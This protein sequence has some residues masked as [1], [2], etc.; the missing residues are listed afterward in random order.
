MIGRPEFLAVDGMIHL[1]DLKAG[2]PFL[3]IF[4][5]RILTDLLH[6]FFIS[7]PAILQGQSIFIDCSRLIPGKALDLNHVSCPDLFLHH[8][9]KGAGTK[10][11]HQKDHQKNAHSPSDASGPFRLSSDKSLCQKLF[12]SPETDA[13]S[14]SLLLLHISP[15]AVDGSDLSYFLRR[16]EGCQ[17]DGKNA[18]KSRYYQSLR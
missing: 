9:R 15:D 18:E 8:L 16:P 7:L 10:S 1:T 5:I 14:F 13:F 3:R 17:K 2:I 6:Q 11:R 12:R 4:G